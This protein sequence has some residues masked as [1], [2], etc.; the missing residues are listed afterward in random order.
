MKKVFSLAI[1]AIL[2]MTVILYSCQKPEELTSPS[3][4]LSQG[5]IKN[6]TD[7]GAIHNSVM[8]EVYN[9]MLI[10]KV[11]P[12]MIQGELKIIAYS[13]FKNKIASSFGFN[14]E[15]ISQFL[16][17]SNI[18]DNYSTYPASIN[19]YRQNMEDGIFGI[20]DD[21]LRDAFIEV[22]NA[23]ENANSL[24]EFNAIVNANKQ[25]FVGT[26]Y[27][28]LYN[29]VASISTSSYDYWANNSQKWLD[30]NL[31]NVQAKQQLDPRFKQI[32]KADIYGAIN[33]GLAGAGFA[34]V[35]ALA[36]AC[37]GASYGSAIEGLFV[38]FGW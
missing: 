37:L 21:Q 10:N 36:G 14:S 32:V 24:D 38:A 27:E 9:S 18:P 12:N 6:R 5:N 23:V 2:S 29:V 13:A 19:N 34:G 7:Y 31:Q 16:I 3:S 1:I 35:G 22:L 25:Q 11:V 17:N 30:L 8:E 4:S 26:S 15:L 28:D 20:N 33:G